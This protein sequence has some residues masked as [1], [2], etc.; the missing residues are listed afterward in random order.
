MHLAP[1]IKDLAV[2]LAVAG[3][4]SLIF[5][6]I[7]QP[8]VLGYILAGMIVGPHAMP[9]Q[10]VTDL[11]SI[12]TWAELGVI[13]LMFSLGLEFSFR[14]LA[15]VGTS[16]AITA[17]TEVLC[18]LP[19]GYGVGKL[20]GWS[21]MDSVFL[22][23]MLAI[24]STTI[25]IKALNELNLKSHRFAE[26]IFGVLIV[27][28]LIAILLLV[29]L[30]TVA[31]SDTISGFALL[32]AAAKLVFVVGSW[33]IVGYFAVPR[34]IQYVGRVGNNEMLT[35]LSLGLC[36]GLVVLASSFQYSTALGAF[37]MGSIL[38]ETPLIHRIEG[39][40]E[41]LR[42]LF[43]AIF[44]VSIGMLIDPQVLWE[45]RWTILALSAITIVGKIFSSG[46]GSLASGQ[47][48]RNSIRVGFG[49]AQIGEFSFIIASLGL[50]LKAT[51]SFIY[52]VAV[53]VSL[54]TTFTT[55]YLIRFSGP[56]SE[57]AEARLPEKIK[58][59]L[60]RYATWSEDR[61]TAAGKRKTLYK[62]LTRWAINGLTIWVVFVLCAELI[63]P[64]M[65][66]HVFG[67]ETEIVGSMLTWLVA[68]AFSSPFIWGMI[69]TF[70]RNLEKYEN[71]EEYYLT[72]LRFFSFRLL[73]LLWIATL[74]SEFLPARYIVGVTTL[75]LVVFLG[76]F[77]GRLEQSY[78][79]FENRFLSTFEV[80]DGG[81]R[82]PEAARL[83]PWDA[84][85]V[86]LQVHPNAAFAGKRLQD[87]QM[88]NKYGVNVVAIQR[89]LES[90]VAPNPT[91]QIFPQ[92]ELL[93]LGTD[94]NIE[95]IRP[96]VEGPGN[97]ILENLNISSYELKHFSVEQNSKS[98]AGSS[99]R[100]SGLRERF[101]SMVV[102]IERNGTRMINPD[103]NFILLP[104]D[105]L[106]VV[107]LSDN[108]SLLQQEFTQER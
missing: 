86:R 57:W 81:G 33:F 106:W 23:A 27:E 2:I 60:N 51:S 101:S 18:L 63:R 56:I 41:S 78:R 48:F 5:Q 3:L 37:I 31:T 54:V 30:N 55:P 49:L 103:S 36:L 99:I 52:P 69:S 14:K 40:M 105:T 66:I 97:G 95:T 90:K 21:S 80:K 6:Q 75:I 82:H 26:L 22:G 39:R 10:S 13:F 88:R 61:R 96:L 62:L 77:Y 11:P 50:S 74:S 12:Q 70:P 102:G 58:D 84:H 25:I 85:L 83:A 73:T 1:L 87:I 107:G 92:D 65:S 35:L 94:K 104:G 15:K 34:F 44:F 93:V 76:L 43:G 100:T 72:R 64:N 53:A 16:A 89:G 91:E 19:L 8:V 71:R 68:V 24:S 59:L 98:F 20:F 28:D 4:M 47:T 108:L 45:H 29:G 17:G 7:R 32:K 42:D 38:A 46:L 79:W 9:I 67:T